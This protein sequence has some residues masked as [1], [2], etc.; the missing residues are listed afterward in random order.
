MGSFEFFFWEV[1][2]LMGLVG[3]LEWDCGTLWGVKNVL[4]C[5]FL[6]GET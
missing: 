2:N 1:I 5:V 4:C 3:G 6:R